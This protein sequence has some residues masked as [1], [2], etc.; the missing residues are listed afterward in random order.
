MASRAGVSLPKSCLAFLDAHAVLVP[1]AQE[2][3]EDCCPATRFLG[4]ACEAESGWRLHSAASSNG[5]AEL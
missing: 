1:H 3:T 5:L 2:L 4:A